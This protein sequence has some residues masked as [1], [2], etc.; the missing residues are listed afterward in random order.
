MAS[1]YFSGYAIVAKAG[2]GPGPSSRG[3]G[4]MSA[5][6]GDEEYFPMAGLQRMRSG[7]T[8]GKLQKWKGIKA[9]VLWFEEIVIA[10]LLLPEDRSWRVRKIEVWFVTDLA[11]IGRRV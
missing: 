5:Q 8:V 11:F 3:V 1:L 2:P 9:V 6:M 4:V 10:K 7:W